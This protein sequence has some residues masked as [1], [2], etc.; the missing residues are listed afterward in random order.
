[1]TDF[2]TEF[3]KQL[4]EGKSAED[5]AAELTKAINDANKQNEELKAKNA[6]KRDKEK[7]E[8]VTY[9]LDAFDGIGR[10]WGIDF[11]MD[12]VTSQE[13]EDI[14]HDLDKFIPIIQEQVSIFAAGPG[15]RQ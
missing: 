8:A 2:T 12:E 14:V 4:Q 1:M 3:L 10:A 13:I 11:G 6:A 5:L 15:R 9:F 7:I